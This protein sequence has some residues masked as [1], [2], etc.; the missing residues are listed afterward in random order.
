MTVLGPDQST[1]TAACVNIGSGTIPSLTL[2]VAGAYTVV[3]DPSGTGD[4]GTR[5]RRDDRAVGRHATIRHGRRAVTV[6]VTLRA[7]TEGLVDRFDAPDRRPVTDF[8]VFAQESSAASDQAWRELRRQCP[9]SWTPRNGGHWTLAGYEEV[10]GAF[11]DWE[12]F[13]SERLDPELCAISIASSRIPVMVPEEA[14]PPRWHGYRRVLAELLSPGAVERLRPRVEHWVDHQI[15]QFIETGSAELAHDLSVPVPAMVTM[16]W[17][18]WPREEWLVAAGTFHE[19][20]KHRPGSDGMAAA[21][22]RFGWLGDRITAEVAERRRH[23]RD[24]AMSLIANHEQ[25]GERL[26]LEDASSIVMLTIG[27]GVD[28]TTALTSAAL[29]HLGR[30]AHDRDRLIAD[31]GVLD[32]ATEEFLRF[33]P[34]ARTHART[35]ARDS[36]FAG[37]VLR[38]G[39]RVVL[40]EI[41]ANHDERSFADADRFVIDRFPNRHVSF[42]V[43]IHRCV[44]SHLARLEFKTMVRRVLERL[45]NFAL[46]DD[47]VVEYPNWSM[48]GGWAAI[49]VTF[50]PGAV[51]LPS[52]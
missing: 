49:P 10:T 21:V 2:P 46:D 40:S 6:P 15:D 23:P 3:V 26:T 27:G 37:C 31:Y 39:D 35:V 48:L 50:S 42:G 32:V 11:R 8:D 24:D 28:T 7:T 20:A 17:L 9:V 51:A 19:M 25:D 4:R 1:L 16:E 34:P 41:A 36:E 44:G 43:G 18:G 38:A 29:V 30:N 13:S 52:G 12:T 47:G 45:P 14:D 5:R 33:Y 22:E